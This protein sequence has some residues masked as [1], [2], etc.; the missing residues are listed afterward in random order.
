MLTKVFSTGD[1][2]R[3]AAQIPWLI[4][5]LGLAGAVAVLAVGGLGW[6]SGAVSLALLAAGG[7][8]AFR[9]AGASGSDRGDVLG[10]VASHQAFGASLAAVWTRQI[11]TSRAHME[12]A[13]SSLAERFG[14]IVE[15]LASTVKVAD[16]T[17]GGGS[18]QDGL[19]AVFS[20]SETS[21]SQV[22][23]SLESALTS[24]Q[25]LVEQIHDLARIAEDLK[26]MAGDV[27]L[28]A[29]QTNLLAIN[30]AIEAA[31]AG[32]T[33]RGFAV[34]AQEVRK[35]SAQS[36]ATGQRIAEK[37]GLVAQAV[38]QT[39]TAA[40]LSTEAERASAETSRMAIANVLME[41]RGITDALVD[42]TTR[43]KN[44]SLGIQG[45]ISE[46][47]V[48]LQFQDRV[49][50]ILGHVRENIEQMP[51]CLAEHQA[52]VASTGSLQPVSAD[53]LLASLEKTYAMAEEREV[54]RPAASTNAASSAQAGSAK[55]AATAHSTQPAES[56]IT[57]F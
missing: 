12:N 38:E 32:E 44:E 28:I 9:A 3:T 16:A 37:V 11:E 14:G 30:A 53:A 35:L 48:Q 31:H 25:S 24:K 54:H 55:R 13:V 57:F 19:V 41:F 34:L 17:T 36:A 22:V 49:G 33:G 7:L 43:L 23:E 56:E 46:A 29:S 8:L 18:D 6:V 15:K 50:Q 21:L 27:A 2:P 5:G 20:R 10:Y 4:A 26:Q 40:D 1:L 51:T 52:Q 45:E 42:S 39:R 47:L